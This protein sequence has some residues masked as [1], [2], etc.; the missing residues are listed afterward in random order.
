MSIVYRKNFIKTE[1]LIFV[2]NYSP[3][4]IDL[5][6]FF[7]EILQIPL[8]YGINIWW[9]QFSSI[10]TSFAFLMSISIYFNLQK[11]TPYLSQQRVSIN[12]VSDFCI[13]DVLDNVCSSNPCQNGG[14]CRKILRGYNCICGELET[15]KHCETSTINIFIS[16]SSSGKISL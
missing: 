7:I 10:Q 16:T 2:W 14:K 1:M 11:S 8:I 13:I 12:L 4:W 15:G 9:D 3:K 6:L 5:K